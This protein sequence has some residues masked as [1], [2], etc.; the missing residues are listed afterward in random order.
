[1]EYCLLVGE[2]VRDD[3]LCYRAKTSDAEPKSEA[4]SFWRSQNLSIGSLHLAIHFDQIALDARRYLKLI[5]H[6]HLRFGDNS[7]GKFQN[8]LYLQ[9]YRGQSKRRQAAP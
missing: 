2:G 7:A 1:M 6:F 4:P 3:S 8:A 5:S 9:T